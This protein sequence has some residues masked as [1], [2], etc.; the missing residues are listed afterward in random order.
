MTREICQLT[1]ILAIGVRHQIPLGAVVESAANSYEGPSTLLDWFHEFYQWVSPFHW[2]ELRRRLRLAKLLREIS[3]D[4][5]AGN[6]LSDSL[7]WLADDLPGYYIPAIAIAE[8]RQALPEVLDNL[9]HLME[10]ELE[11]AAVPSAL[12]NYLGWVGGLCLLVIFF[13]LPGVTGRLLSMHAQV[14]PDRPVPML[15]LLMVQAPHHVPLL[16][17]ALGMTLVLLILYK[18]VVLFSAGRLAR[19]WL[20]L[21]LPLVGHIVRLQALIELG[22]GMSS[23]LTLG[24]DLPAAATAVADSTERRW[25]KRR[26]QRFGDRVAYGES[27]TAA[28][29][30]SGLGNRFE[31][32]VVIHG[33]LRQEPAA[34]FVTLALL[35]RQRL[36]YAL[37]LTRKLLPVVAVLLAGLVVGLILLAMFLPIIRIA[38]YMTYWPL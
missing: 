23:Y 33:Q 14:H 4:L 31:R 3:A 28:W 35:A 10:Q 32:W 9:E 36:D 27:W 11:I 30:Q 16:V 21:R 1:K 24:Y 17:G 6:S 15:S 22:H 7:D 12:Y 8:Q 37:N 34:G 13:I 19:E 38:D 20:A 5:S 29:E 18:V 2:S 25:L 26:L